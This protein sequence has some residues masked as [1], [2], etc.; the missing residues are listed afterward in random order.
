MR[1]KHR[2]QK[3]G[4]HKLRYVALEKAEKVSKKIAVRYID[5]P[6]STKSRQ[7]LNLKGI[8]TFSKENIENRIK[9]INKYAQI[10]KP[11]QA[12][13]LMPSERQAPFRTVNQIMKDQH[14]VKSRESQISQLIS[15]EFK[16]RDID[17]MK[18]KIIHK[19][20]T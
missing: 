9:M 7:N 14:I 20:S 4:E 17:P 11:K 6:A 19:I 13:I 18:L 12:K 2:I 15:R 8:P 16:E 3:M 10:V 1:H 5:K